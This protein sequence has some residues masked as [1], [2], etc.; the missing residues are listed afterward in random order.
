MK[1]RRV[2]STSLSRLILN[3][4]HWRCPNLP[5]ISVLAHLV[6]KPELKCVHQD[7]PWVHLLKNVNPYKIIG[8]SKKTIDK[9]VQCPKMAEEVMPRM[10]NRGVT[11]IELIV[12]MVIIAIAAAFIAPNI[13]AWIPNYRLRGATRDVVSTLR[14]AQMKAV[15]TNREYQVSFDPGARSYILQYRDT[16]GTWI[17][18]GTAQTLATG[19]QI[20]NITFT[21][22]N[23]QF[24][25]NSTSSPGSIRLTNT[26]G[27]SKTITLTSSTGRAKID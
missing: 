6:V 12:V 17:N 23:A 7:E 18:E 9:K 25:P 4:S 22:N 27:T 20:S 21:G 11:L 19:I 3:E 2:L 14:T 10:K 13:G 16:G 5:S 15:S 26:K 1:E 24:N 8:I